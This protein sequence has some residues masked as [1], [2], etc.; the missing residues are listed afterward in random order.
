MNWKKVIQRLRQ[1]YRANQELAMSLR[2]SYPFPE[3][4]INR[5]LLL[6]DMQASLATALECGLEDK[7]NE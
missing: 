3:A 4:H 1:Q 7:E 5:L 2:S 6:S